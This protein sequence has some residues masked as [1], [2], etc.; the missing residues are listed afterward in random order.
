MVVPVETASVFDEYLAE[1]TPELREQVVIQSVPLVYYLVNR[2]GFSAEMGG[3]YEDLVNQGFLGLI[4]AVDRFDPQVG[5][6]FSTYA[7]LRIR[8]KIID[9]LRSSD[10]MSRTKRQRARRIEEATS[11]LWAENKREPTEEEIAARLGITTQQV[12][13]GLEDLNRVLL[14]LDHFDEN[15]VDSDSSLYERLGDENQP[16]PAHWIEKEDQKQMMIQALRQL[17]ERD[18]LILSLYYHEE[19]TFKEIG[20]VLEITESRVC[21]LHARIV[22]NLKKTMNYDY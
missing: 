22:M 12:Q 20:K 3:E 14:S 2:L 19:L 9:Y 6:R 7:S 11:S 10:W 1:R 4:D 16:D 21:Q 17:S 8:G 15:D 5:A 13:Q 18:Q